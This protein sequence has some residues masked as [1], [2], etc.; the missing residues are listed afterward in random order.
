MNLGPGVANGTF[1]HL[2]L[3]DVHVSDNVCRVLEP[4][5]TTSRSRESCKELVIFAREIVELSKSSRYLNL[6]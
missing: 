5:E 1:H 4:R 3:L 6:S 2:L